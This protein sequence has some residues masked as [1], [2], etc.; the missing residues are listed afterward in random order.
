MKNKDY[1]KSSS[2]E[3]MLIIADGD[4]KAFEELL[5]RH[6]KKAWCIAY[7]MLNNNEDAEDAV[8]ESF[9]K[10]YQNAER[11]RTRAKFST[12]FYRIIINVCIDHLRKSKASKDQQI[13]DD[14]PV[15]DGSIKELLDGERKEFIQKA[16]DSL[17]ENQKVAIIMKHYEG[18]QYKEIADVLDTTPKA[19][20]SLIA[21]A[22]KTLSKILSSLKE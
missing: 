19:I 20:E 22:R 18:M 11:Y 17:P 4:H 1:K 2:E 14:V 12:F 15:M 7:K 5:L 6:Q 21:R 16:I 8:Q 9:I 13:T 3:L 10:L